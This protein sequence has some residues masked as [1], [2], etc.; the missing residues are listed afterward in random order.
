[1]NRF[2]GGALETAAGPTL[3][4]VGSLI[5]TLNDFATLRYR[6]VRTSFRGAGVQQCLWLGAVREYLVRCAD[7]ELPVVN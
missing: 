7:D 4:S 5:D 6:A 3:G 2:G 1:M